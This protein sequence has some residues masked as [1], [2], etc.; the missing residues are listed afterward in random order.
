MCIATRKQEKLCRRERAKKNKQ[1]NRRNCRV[2]N[3]NIKQFDQWR[4]NLHEKKDL[5]QSLVSRFMN[6][7]GLTKSFQVLT[8]TARLFF[9]VDM[10]SL[11]RQSA[12][13]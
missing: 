4:L 8:L 13:V 12:F 11:T 3:R 1:S 10:R 7:V 9:F 5:K 2:R 6:A